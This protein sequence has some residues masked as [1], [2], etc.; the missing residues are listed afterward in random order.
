[1]PTRTSRAHSPRPDA[2][3][4]DSEESSSRA[5][6]RDRGMGW[7]RRGGEVGRQGDGHGLAHR[8]AASDLAGS[9]E[10]PSPPPPPPGWC[11]SAASTPRCTA[12]GTLGPAASIKSGSRAELIQNGWLLSASPTV[13]PA[14]P[15]WRSL[16]WDMLNSSRIWSVSSVPDKRKPTSA[17][18]A[19]TSAAT[20][21]GSASLK[22]RSR[23]S[24]MRFRP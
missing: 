20:A 3:S 16:S 14:G 15:V 12:A 1:M 10:C 8:T 5:L 19:S 17:V 2:L 13:P 11:S 24:C 18:P 6:L 22:I 23:G 9:H 4:S 7:R 21:A